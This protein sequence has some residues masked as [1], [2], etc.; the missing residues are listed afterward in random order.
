MSEFL[1]LKSPRDA[2]SGYL[3]EIESMVEF[4]KISTFEGLGRVI[5]EDIRASHPLP[6][7]P[8]STVDGYAVIA[9]NTFGANN[10]LP[11]Y[12]QI[13]GEVP[14]GT[15]SE[16]IVSE[17]QCALI[18]TGGMIPD[19]AN[20]VVMLENTQFFNGNELEVYKA[21]AAGENVIQ[22]GE[23]VQD[24][25]LVIPAGTRLRPAEIGGLMAFGIEDI[26]V[27]RKPLIGII[28]T[29]D[30]IISPDMLIQPGLI[31]DI[32]SYSLRSIGIKY[33]ANVKR[34][35]IAKDDFYQLKKI[36][37]EA[38][39]E[40]D[41]TVITAGSSASYRDLTAK[42][43]DA[44]G[45]PGVLIHGVNIK[46]GKPTILGICS[47]KPVIG[48]PGNPVSALV[49]AER[50][51]RPVI[52]CLLGVQ[53]T[54]R[55]HFVKAEMV[56]NLASQAGREDWIP[57]KFIFDEKHSSNL[58]A[59]PIYGRSNL[60]FILVKADGLALVDSESTG[61]AKGEDVKVYLLN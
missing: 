31:R 59:E 52:D 7:F 13:I 30:E 10:S 53:P 58:Y 47:N 39:E 22:I 43:I 36:A 56:T 9:Q 33:G 38:L 49:I 2:L 4:E 46:P 23:D 54:I 45:E 1:K 25:E 14:M 48:M 12:L 28:S 5:A 27:I 8:R 18:H 42:V 19:G 20:A 41:I 17:S 21:V 37:A 3:Q 15:Q 24:D 11:A 29:G 60:I 35:G 61:I 16:L 34:Y 26:D 6:D 40:S 32:N 51:V 50:F 57:V 44:L 55:T